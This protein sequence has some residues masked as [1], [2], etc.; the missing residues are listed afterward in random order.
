MKKLVLFAA[1][2][3]AVSFTSCKKEYSCTI[4][5][6]TSTTDEDLSD[7]EADDFKSTCEGAGGTY[8]D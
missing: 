7:D 3:G 6:V 2:L 4:D 1:V 8:E 5:G